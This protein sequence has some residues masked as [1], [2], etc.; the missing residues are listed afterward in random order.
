M[1]SRLR[2]KTYGVGVKGSVAIAVIGPRSSIGVIRD[3]A[4]DRVVACFNVAY[5]ELPPEFRTL[6]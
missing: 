5:V 2:L 1:K 4:S 3:K 6:T